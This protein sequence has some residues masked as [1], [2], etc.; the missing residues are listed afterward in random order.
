LGKTDCTSCGIKLRKE[1]LIMGDKIVKNREKKKK[2]AE[3]KIIDPKSLL[4][5]ENKPK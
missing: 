4:S 1:K 3:K 2:K 5:S